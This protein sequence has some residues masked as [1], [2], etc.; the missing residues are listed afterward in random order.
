MPIFSHI[1]YYNSEKWAKNMPK[2]AKNAFSAD[3]GGHFGQV[4]IGLEQPKIQNML[5]STF[6]YIIN[7]QMLKIPQK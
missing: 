4:P 2:C 7:H 3:F 1:A 5:I 6:T